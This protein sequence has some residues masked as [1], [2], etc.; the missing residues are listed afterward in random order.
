[1]T[2][3]KKIFH[4]KVLLFGEHIINKGAMGLAVPF[5]HYDGVLRFYDNLDDVK[6]AE[7]NKSL[8]LLADYI[9]HHPTLSKLYDTNQ[10][11]DDIDNNLYFDSDIPQGYGLGSSGALVAAIYYQYRKG[12]KKNYVISELKQELAEIESYFHSKSSGLDPIV[13]FLEKAV[14]ISKGEVAEVFDMPKPKAPQVKIFLINTGIARK[15]SPFVNLFLEKYNDKKF[16]TSIEKSL[17]PATNIA[18]AGYL[19][20]KYADFMKSVKIISQLHYDLMPEFIPERFKD[21]WQQGLKNNQYY[22]KV[23][24]AG[25]GGFILGFCKKDADLNLLLSGYEVLEMGEM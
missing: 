4:S 18:I 1:M 12:K 5:K 13:C 16:S 14:L 24:G 21:V 20:S 25:G 7:S 2:I 23:C 6:V 22:L 11:L 15:T 19:Q 3:K 10:L 9:I 8:Q 17:V